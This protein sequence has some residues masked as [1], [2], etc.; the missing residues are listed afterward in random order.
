MLVGFSASEGGHMSTVIPCVYLLFILKSF[1]NIRTGV[2]S[3]RKLTER[4][5]QVFQFIREH[6]EAQGCPPTRAEIAKAMGFRS[7][8]AAEDHLRALARKNVIILKQGISRGI[9]LPEM[10]LPLVGQVA[11]GQPILAEE[12][13]EDYVRVKSNMF[14]EAADFFLR[15]RGESMRDIGIMHG[16][17]LAVRRTTEVQ[18]GQIVVARVGD[19]VTVKRFFKEGNHIRLLAEN[20]EFAPIEI[21]LSQQNVNIEGLGVGVL[22][23]QLVDL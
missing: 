16:D 8:N 14:C 2:F 7:I 15:V 22:R 5:S 20:S 11:A 18:N 13:I 3:M 23:T 10:G 12:H 6:I 4:Q 21:D 1:L 9:F 17:L 19:E